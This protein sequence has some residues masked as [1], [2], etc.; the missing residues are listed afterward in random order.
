M[1]RCP[2]THLS[3]PKARQD[4]QEPCGPRALALEGPRDVTATRQLPPRVVLPQAPVPKA[5][6]GYRA[7]QRLRHSWGQR[8]SEPVRERA[9]SPGRPAEKGESMP[10]APHSA[11]QEDT[12]C[13]GHTRTP[14]A[15]HTAEQQ[16]YFAHEVYPGSCSVT[17]GQK[18]TL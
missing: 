13:G 15:R 2:H 8:T 1:R 14:S 9:G 4:R 5:G 7:Q 11:R 18:I 17:C 16:W 6:L 3:T 10:T 12:P